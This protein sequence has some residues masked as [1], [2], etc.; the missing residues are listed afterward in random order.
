LAP[1][2]QFLTS[3]FLRDKKIETY[4]FEIAFLTFFTDKKIFAQY[5][6][7]NLLR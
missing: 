2:G 3:V 1:T 5:N 7:L 6:L 4:F